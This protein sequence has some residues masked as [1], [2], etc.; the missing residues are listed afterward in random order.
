MKLRKFLNLVKN[1]I[2]WLRNK[3]EIKKSYL[4][5]DIFCLQVI[6]RALVMQL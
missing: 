2:L 6:E 5:S 1:N 4:M 3:L